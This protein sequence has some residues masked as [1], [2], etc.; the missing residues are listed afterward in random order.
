MFYIEYMYLEN[1]L[2]CNIEF[3]WGNYWY[4]FKVEF[5]F[6]RIFWKVEKWNKKVL[7]NIYFF[8]LI[9]CMYMYFEIEIINYKWRIDMIWIDVWKDI[10]FIFDNWLKYFKNISIFIR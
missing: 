4:F 3:F 1:V 7:F 6:I 10:L 8:V 2:F 9:V 5:F